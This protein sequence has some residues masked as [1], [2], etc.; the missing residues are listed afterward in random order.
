MFCFETP[1]FEFHSAIHA[2][3]MV[4]IL[5]V[6]KHQLS[7]HSQGDILKITPASVKKLRK[8]LQLMVKNLQ[9]NKYSV[10]PENPSKG[11]WMGFFSTRF[12]RVQQ[13]KKRP[14]SFSFNFK[15]FLNQQSHIEIITAVG[16]I[17]SCTLQK[18][19]FRLDGLRLYP[20]LVH[21]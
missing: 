16:G 19:Q 17:T 15:L 11:E 20:I 5:T 2:S 9:L 4:F 1:H 13:E 12:A 21:G 8:V 14:R 7:R 10:L 3:K 18:V 6:L